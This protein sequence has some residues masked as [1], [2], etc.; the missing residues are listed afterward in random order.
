VIQDRLKGQLEHSRQ[1]HESFNKRAAE[2]LHGLKILLKNRENDNYNKDVMIATLD[3]ELTNLIS[4]CS[5]F[6]RELIHI[7]VICE[8]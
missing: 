5:E 8:R 3:K 6:E 7:R 2:E 4:R 1:T